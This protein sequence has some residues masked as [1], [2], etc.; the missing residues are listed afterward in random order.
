MQYTNSKPGRGE[1]RYWAFVGHGRSPSKHF[2]ILAEVVV[3]KIR[4]DY[5]NDY[6]IYECR[7]V[8]IFADSQ[9]SYEKGD[10]T[11]VDYPWQLQS[12]LQQAQALTIS[13]LFKQGAEGF[14]DST[15]PFVE[16]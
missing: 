16:D 14:L 13:T 7:F 8:D 15:P 12:T 11:I 5:E 10:T 6:D 3:E 2:I 4:W 1:T 9:N